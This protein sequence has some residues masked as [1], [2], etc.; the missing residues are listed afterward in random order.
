MLGVSRALRCVA[1]VKRNDNASL[2]VL[3]DYVR[4][5][6]LRKEETD[7]AKK[8]ETFRDVPLRY[9][10]LEVLPGQSMAT[11]KLKYL[12]ACRKHHPEVGGDPEM[13]LRVSLAYQDCMK[14]YGIETVDNKIV[15]LGNFQSCDHEMKNYLEARA[16]ITSYIPLST[17][18]DHINQLEM[19]HGRLGMELSGKLSDNSDEAFWLQEDIDKIVE[20]TGI[21]TVHVSMLAD[22]SLKVK[23]VATPA[24]EGEHTPLIGTVSHDEPA[25]PSTTN[26]TAVGAS[27]SGTVK[28]PEEKV[29]MEAEVSLEDI[30]CL[31][32]KHTVQK[33]EDVAGLASRVATGVMN[34]TKEKFQVRFEA[35]VAATIAFNLGFLIL[36]YLDAYLRAKREE[37]ERPQVREHITTDTMLPWWGNDT[38][39]EAQ[40]KRIFVDEWRRARSSSRRVQVFQDGVARESLPL[41]TKEDLDVNIFSV[42]AEKLQKM[43]LHAEEQKGRQ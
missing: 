25:D 9:Q 3:K 36:A 12:L 42:T 5:A 41:S 1:I 40:V 37:E 26:D 19:V 24:L 28:E 6:A 29:V 38:E 23:P 8:L 4:T 21:R 18:D 11:T 22:G 31:N 14:D 16:R 2:P 34:N 39:Y 17:L 20:A 33:R 43:R 13:F 35:M 7:A 27:T 32:A 30:A 15:N 10:L